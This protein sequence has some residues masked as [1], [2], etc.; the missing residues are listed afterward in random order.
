MSVTFTVT[1]RGQPL[2]RC[3]VSHTDNLRAPST[4]FF[5]TDENGQVTVTNAGRANFT[6]DPGGP[7]GNIAV[8]VH[9]QNS[10]V[11]VLDGDANG[12]PVAQTF[13][14][15]SNGDTINI[16]TD[17]ERQDHFR[18]MD[19]C[20]LVY[21]RVFRGLASPFFLQGRRAFPFGRKSNI[22]E[23]YT[24]LP[25]IEVLYPD[26]NPVP[27]LAYVEP[28]SLTM[29][30]LIHLKHRNEDAT[31][32]GTAATEATLIP[33]ELA[34]ALYMALMPPAT[35]A[36]VE[37]QYLAWLTARVAGGLP[38][39]HNT[40]LATT[41]FVAWVECLGIFSERFFFFSQQR[42]DLSFGALWTAFVN[43]ELSGAPLLQNLNGYQI[44]GTVDGAGN[45]VPELVGENVE[46]A[47]YGAIFLDFARRTSLRDAVNLYMN[48]GDDNVL[49]FDDFRNL[50]ITDTA[51]D[52]HIEDVAQT[53]QL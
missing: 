48:S 39:F 6:L 9:A 16:N 19:K 35:R 33:H 46:G 17:A 3:Y 26:R 24:V 45:V 22:N 2:R 47:L 15:V 11:R 29:N 31:L 36:S 40:N 51:F 4:L 21:D 5:L 27:P 44:V 37:A 13:N 14:N 28:L 1:L 53:W 42:P 49:N 23:M 7:G 12:T 30:P 43:D 50:V 52:Q 32:F 25:R 18:I 41:P 10:V 38:P 20:L 8:T 34:H